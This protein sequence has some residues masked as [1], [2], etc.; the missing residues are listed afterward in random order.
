MM[1]DAMIG[2]VLQAL[3]DTQLAANTLVLFTSDNGPVWY[4]EDVQRTGHNSSGGL[5]GMKSSN[6]EA[7]HRMPFI[8]RWP[9]RVKAGS[10]AAQTVCFTD[11][12]ATL[13]A[14]SGATLG[15][16]DG[17]DSFNFLPV[18]L[19]TQPATQ[20]VR[21][22]LVIGRSIRS[23][24]WKWIEGRE[25]LHFGRPASGTYPAASEPPGQL[26]DLES[27]PGETT[28]L[29]ATQPEVVTRLKAESARIQQS[30]RTRP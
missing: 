17:P 6:W 4:P 16:E 8:V 25:A 26:Y 23:G 14:V 19:G 1:V 20:P 13:A 5:R 12:M 21:E 30:S 15:P 24:R 22:S 2:R 3:D 27:D 7:G 18:L 29:A 10:T 28:N 11:V 9:G